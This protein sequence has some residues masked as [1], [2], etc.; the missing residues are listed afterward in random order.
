[1]PHV[2]ITGGPGVGKTTL[3]AA[4]GRAGHRTAPESA[5]ALIAERQAAGLPP[6]PPA[7]EFAQEILRRDLARLAELPAGPDWCFFDRSAVEALGLVH[8]AGGGSDAD[9]AARLAHL[10]FHRTV[11]I[12]PPWREIYTTDAERDHDWAHVARVDAALRAWYGRC[13]YRL[14]DV[15]RGPVEARVA[16]VLQSLGGTVG[17]LQDRPPV[18]LHPAPPERA[19]DYIRLRGLTRENAVPAE[20]LA[21]L[22]I[23]AATWSEDIRRGE[24]TGTM[25]LAGDTLVGYG[26]GSLS[27]GEVVVLALDPAF[28]GRGLGR[29]LLQ[30]VV[31][32]LRRAGHTRLFLGCAAD[33][34][35]RSH[36]FYRHLGWRS[37][38]T[39]DRYGDEVLELPATSGP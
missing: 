5:R 13:G 30:A 12:L 9:L 20:R 23:T 11:F 1:M 6:R 34:A 33:P 31:D 22:G 26:F 2:V 18:T 3:L 21:A 15:P 38:G 37:T 10:P 8:E 17:T 25:A 36:G 39:V 28:E 27:T 35:V 14:V 32:A 29:Q 24:L 19:A 4:L 7:L 16:F